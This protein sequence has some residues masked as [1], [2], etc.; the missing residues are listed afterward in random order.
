MP[1]ILVDEREHRRGLILGLTL[2][3]VLLLLLFLLMLALAV[4]LESAYKERDQFAAALEPA[5]RP[6]ET[7]SI[8]TDRASAIKALSE[9]LARLSTLEK[10]VAEL[11]DAN[12]KLTATMT[13]L[14]TDPQKMQNAAG[15]IEW[16]TKINPTDPPA[17]LKRAL[18]ILEVLG[19]STQPQDVATLSKMRAERDAAFGAGASQGKHNWPPIITLSEADGYFFDT[20]SANLSDE[21]RVALSGRVVAKLLQTVEEFEVDIIEVIGHTDEQRIVERPSNLDKSLIPFLQSK[22]GTDLFVPADNAGLGLA[23]AASVAR[24]LSTDTRLANIRV[25][26]LS[27]AQLIDVGD[28][29]ATGNNAGDVR[30]RRRIEI[31]V[32]RSSR[33]ISA[34]DGSGVLEKHV[35]QSQRPLSGRAVVVDGDTIDIGNTRVRIWG[36]DA[37]ES[38]QTCTKDGNAWDCGRLSSMAL[39]AHLEGQMIACQP[40]DRD[41][42]GRVVATCEARGSDVGAW[43]VARGLA[44]DCPQ[45]SHGAYADEQVIARAARRGIWRGDFVL[46]WEWRQGRRQ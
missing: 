11:E 18:E 1:G 36:I 7:G 21:F 37:I 25:L 3:E 34:G 14:K 22:P 26:P 13:A 17:V 32:R 19:T 20:G 12:S 29:L 38:G 41:V 15:A 33:E 31:R 30:Q 42:Y 23:R 28:T 6:L 9:R 5:V 40:K 24:V 46:P 44:V 16:A 43:L 4:R 27:A 35:V 39:K 10:R 2:A 8:S 45:Y